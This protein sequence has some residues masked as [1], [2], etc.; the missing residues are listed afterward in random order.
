MRILIDENLP[1]KLVE[2]L[3]E[4]GHACE[5]VHTLKLQGLDNGRLFTFAIQNFDLCLTRDFGFAHNA[6]QAA[7]PMDFR[8]V[9]VSLPQQR[10]ELFV[11]EFMVHFHRT[12][13][14]TVRNGT[15][16]PP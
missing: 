11:A 6:A 1:R 5:S 3:R 16:W 9:R 12:D 15:D 2:A 4:T 13:W 7:V 10:Q 8:L 14:S